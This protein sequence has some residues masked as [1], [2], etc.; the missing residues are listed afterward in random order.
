MS[1]ISP[2]P[3]SRRRAI[4][5]VVACTVIGALAQ[6]LIKTGANGL[7]A[8]LG[9]DLPSML[10]IVSNG[11]VFAGYTLYAI[12]MVVLVLALREAELSILYPIIALTYVWVSLLSVFVLHE[13]MN[14]ARVSGIALIILGVVAIGRES[15]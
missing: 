15:K 4:L 9:L 12:N 2:A 8:H 10:A 14:V 3:S 5:M 7:P 13:H 1:A 6:L 11:Y